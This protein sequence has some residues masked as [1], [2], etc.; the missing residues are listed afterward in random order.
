MGIFN[1][2]VSQFK[3]LTT[4]GL[5]IALLS[6]YI[7]C[8]QEQPSQP[9]DVEPVSKESTVLV[10]KPSTI[11]VSSDEDY[12]VG[13]NDV[14]D[15]KIE[16]AP[17]LTNKYR[18]DSKGRLL[19]PVIGEINAKNKTIDKIT[20][21]IV[22]RLKG[23]YLVNP[24]VSVRVEQ[25]NSRA[26]F[27]Q[28]A[29]P[30]PGTYQIEGS[31]SLLKLI[32][33]AG[34]LTKE[35]GTNAVIMRKIKVPPVIKN[36]DVIQKELENPKREYEIIKV[37]IDRLFNGDF[38]QNITIMPGDIVNI[39]FSEL[40][41]MTGSVRNPGA[42]PLR[43][44][45]TLLQ[46]ISLAGGLSEADGLIA[47]VTRIR[48]NKKR[49]NVNVNKSIRDELSSEVIK[50][51]IDNLLRGKSKENIIIRPGDFIHIAKMGI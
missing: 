34:G 46:A 16:D 21:E 19:L 8:Q 40:F 14:L 32:T 45:T 3:S 51:N 9:I 25:S 47:F 31:V 42:Y 12:L 28:G 18:I 49:S 30:R 39:P 33:I 17:E 4:S 2:S 27:I 7:I 1:F 15:I 6:S 44:N 36:H 37:N 23:D 11:I 10:V 48:V 26:F 5:F 43:K 24:I 38:G 29:V 50:I 20:E 35:H 13:H 41:F 22:K